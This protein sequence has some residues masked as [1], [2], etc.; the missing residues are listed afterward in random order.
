MHTNSYLKTVIDSAS[1]QCKYR[2]GIVPPHIVAAP[3]RVN[4]IGEH[5]DYN[6]GF[7]LPM[8]IERYVVIAADTEENSATPVAKLFSADM[9]ESV[10]IPLDTPLQP[11]FQSWSAY[12]AGVIA[13][14]QKRNIKIPSFNAVISS[15]LPLGAGLSSSAALEVAMATLLEAITG[16]TLEPAEKALLCQKAEHEFAGVP[17]GIMDQFSSVFGKQNE[18]ILLDCQ[19]QKIEAI[20]FITDDVTILITNTNTHHEL[21]DGEYATRRSQCDSALEKLNQTSWREIKMEDLE[22]T[23]AKLTEI[24]YRRAHHIITEIER[25]TQ[26]AKAFAINDWTQVG[27]LMNASHRSLRNDFQVS[28]KEL[29]I[30]VELALEMSDSVYGSRMT[31][32]GFGGSTV[33]LMKTD[34]AETVQ[35]TLN[36]KYQ[37]QTGLTPQSFITRP[38]QGAHIITHN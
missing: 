16:H 4:L 22:N 24:E 36:E 3:G 19:S 29:D 20:P 21:A 13:G 2:Y 12:I 17:C 38:A 15:N 5:I 26:A 7:V 8:A 23:R 11:G 9:N 27:K 6:D 31:G 37:E 1:N 35:N 25:T 18:L 14:F 34:H 10:S 30:L 33:T 32:A 28:C